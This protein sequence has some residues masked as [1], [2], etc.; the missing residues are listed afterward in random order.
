M[1]TETRTIESFDK[2]NF[3]DFGTLILTQGEQEALTIEADDELMNDL[4]SEVRD[5]KLY[6]GLEEDWF[7]R[8]GKLVSSIFSSSNYKVTYYL[9]FVSLEKLS[10]S[11]KCNLK[12]DAIKSDSLKVNVSGYGDLEFGRIEANDL[13]VNISGRGEFK[14]EGLAETQDISISGSGEYQA[15]DLA[16]QS[17][18][19]VISGQGNAT[20]RVAENLDITISGVGQVNYYGRPKL[21]QVISGMGKSKR[22]TDG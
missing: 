8:L 14:G 4:I 16:S 19:V 20:L 1:K 22:L 15:P 21:R 12:C 6:L 11:G 2:I 17:A 18:K 7:A 5:G 13:K 10:V 3:K 9:T